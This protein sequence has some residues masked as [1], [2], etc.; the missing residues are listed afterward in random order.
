M[1]SD[2]KVIVAYGQC[3]CGAQA[4]SQSQNINHP[5]NSTG[6]PIPGVVVKIVDDDFNE[7]P[8][9][10]RGNILVNTPCG[11]LEY[12]KRPDATKKYF[13]YENGVRWNCTGDI[14]SMGE[15]GDLFV[16]GRAEDYTMVDGNKVFNF[17]VESA[18]SEIPEIRIFDCISKKGENGE[19]DLGLHIVFTDEAKEKYKDPDKLMLK[20]KEIQEAVY[21]KYEDLKMV[22]KYFKIRDSFPY[23]PSGKRDTEALTKETEG[24]IHVDNSYLKGYTKMKR[25]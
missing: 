13:H 20:L 17:D 15:L 3:E 19:S 8:Y 10:E 18:V 14:G 23:K 21:N 4:T 1:G 5:D 16:E 24:F 6:I 25:I 2:V 11:M 22:P 12:Y 9:G 7:L